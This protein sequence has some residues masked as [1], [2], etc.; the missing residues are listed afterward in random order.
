MG[1]LLGGLFAGWLGERLLGTPAPPD[2]GEV[3]YHLSGGS[4]KLVARGSLR[5]GDVVCVD[6]DGLVRRWSP[7]WDEGPLGHAMDDSDAD[8]RVRVRIGG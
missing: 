4:F 5:S 1:R 7:D 2:P 3:G 6:D 8:G